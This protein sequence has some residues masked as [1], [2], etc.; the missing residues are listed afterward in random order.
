MREGERMSKRD[1]DREGERDAE[2]NRH[3]ATAD[4]AK[5]EDGER[6]GRYTGKEGGR[7]TDGH[8]NTRFIR[9][10]LVKHLL[11]P[12]AVSGIADVTMAQTDKQS[13]F[14]RSL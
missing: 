9:Q 4:E 12:G 1:K 8:I 3:T 11:W 7:E 13:L 10:M 14:S 6:R 2:V 5:R